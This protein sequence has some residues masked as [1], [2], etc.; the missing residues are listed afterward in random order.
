MKAVLVSTSPEETAALVEL[1]A[2]GG[3]SVS[4]TTTRVRGRRPRRPG[5]RQI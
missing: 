1:V 4:A 2:D 5:R 3:A